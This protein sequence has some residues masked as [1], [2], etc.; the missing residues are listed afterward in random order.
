MMKQSQLRNFGIIA[1][2]D[3]GKTTLV[4]A[5]LQ[6]SGL[7][8]A[9]QVVEDRI[10]DR[11]DLEKERGITILAKTTSIFYKGYKLN[12]VDTPGHADFGG[13]VERIVRMVDGVLLLVDAFEGP[14]P[15]TRFVLRKALEAKLK[16]IVVVNKID[17][18]NARPAEVLDEVLDLFIELMADEAQLDFPV[19]YTVAKAGLATLDLA[20]PAVDLQ[21]LFDTIIEHIPA[22]EGDP[23]A[24]LQI[25]VAIV[26]HDPYLGRKAIGRVVNG[27]VQAKQPV[28][29]LRGDGSCQIQ[30]L[31]GLFVF[32]GLKEVPVEAAGCGEIV[33]LTGLEDINPGHTVADPEQPRP[34][35]FVRIDEPTVR[36]T[37]QVN[38]SP[39]AGQDGEYVTSRK[40]RERLYRE[41]EADVSLRVQDT[42]S[43]D[44][45]EVAGRGELH[46]SILIERMRR[47]GYEFEVSRPQVIVREIDGQKCEPIEELV[48]EVE[49]QHVGFVMESL[50]LRKGELQSM[51][52]QAD[53]RVRMRFLAPTRGLFGFRSEFLTGTRGTGTMYHSFDHFGPW[54]GEISSRARGSLVAFET[55]EATAY[56]IEHAQERGELF[57]KPGDRVYRGMIVGEHARPGD[58]MINVAKKKQLTNIRS[59]TQEIAVKLNA[60][61][62][63]TLEKALEF[64]ADDELLE[65]TPK[66]FRMRKKQLP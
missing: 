54:K 66:H 25:G 14:M 64:I 6:Q 31:S 2:V 15:Q 21:P 16:P 27:R 13:E 63:M 59:S 18:P 57:I 62:L 51:D 17:R 7:F 19:V 5:M 40:L 38:K 4:N 53:G 47:E 24:P 34:L 37:F 12:I 49:D 33:L 58:L 42:D 52:H 44:V 23:E 56:G 61:R 41:A 35:D 29:V 10:L 3:H 39:F 32:E 48:V 26:D 65:V 36:V 43:P 46:L 60:P 20:V 11:Y 50:G 55:G 8:H 22:P 9:K 30:R 45:F 28:A 1:H